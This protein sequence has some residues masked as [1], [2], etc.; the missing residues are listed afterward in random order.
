MQVVFT[1]AEIPWIIKS[2]DGWH[3]KKGAPKSIAEKV[4]Q[5]LNIIKQ[6]E[7]NTK[8]SRK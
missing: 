7:R 2:D 1:D 5:K 4:T 8:N 6:Y 3:L